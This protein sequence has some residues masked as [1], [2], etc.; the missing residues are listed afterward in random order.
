MNFWIFQRAVIEAFGFALYE[1][2]LG[3]KSGSAKPLAGFGG[4]SVLELVEDHKG[5]TF[6]A[7]YT[8]K[9]ADTIY[10]LHCFQKKST[11]G[12]ETPKPTIELIKRRLKLA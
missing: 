6:R 9:L 3:G 5:D 1:A 2:Q 11:K 7:V 10:V 4:A 8:V 12:I